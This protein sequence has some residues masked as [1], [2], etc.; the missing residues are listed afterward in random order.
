[1]VKIA[2]Q[3]SGRLRYTEQCLGSMI[4]SLIETLNPDVFCSFWN[5]ENEDTKCFYQ[6]A[7]KPKLIEFENQ[8]LVDP[9]LDEFFQYNLHKNLPKMVYKFYKVNQL[10]KTYEFSNKMN[11]DLV[12]QARS[13]NI[14]F[15]KLRIDVC[16][17]ALLEDK[18]LC[19]NQIFTPDIDNYIERPRMVDNFYLGPAYLVDKVSNSFWSLKEICNRLTDLGLFHHVRIPE[20]LQT[21]MWRELGVPIGGLPGCGQY[22][23][24]WYDIDRSDTKWK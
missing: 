18:I 15:E 5:T 10:R 1:M 4:G 21:I 20:I 22:G 16:N 3:I 11:Y 19:S 6:A 14:F 2:L 8:S 12:I 13:D 9:Y 7:L 23:N 17:W 24:F